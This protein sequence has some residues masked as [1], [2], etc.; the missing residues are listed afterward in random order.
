[1]KDWSILEFENWNLACRVLNPSV[2]NH[3]N[4]NLVRPEARRYVRRYMTSCI[5]VCYVVLPTATTAGGSWCVRGRCRWYRWTSILLPR[6]CVSPT[7]ANS[8]ICPRRRSRGSCHRKTT[9]RRRRGRSVTEA[10]VAAAAAAAEE[11][12]RIKGSSISV[13]WRASLFGK[14]NK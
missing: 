8:I 2:Y 7:S 6:N 13:G 5:R 4:V 14:E 3:G 12:D 9:C 10:D 11:E 1:M